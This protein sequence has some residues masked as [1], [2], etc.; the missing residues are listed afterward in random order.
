M[1]YMRSARLF[2]LILFIGIPFVSM[3]Q[4]LDTHPARGFMPNMDQ[5]S[6]PIDN[7]AVSNGKLHLQIPLASLPRG[8]AG[9]GFDLNLE[10]DSHIYD[11]PTVLLYFFDYVNY[12][13]WPVNY[14]WLESS[15]TG[16]GWTYN[17]NNYFIEAE[18][19]AGAIDD[20][21]CTENPLFNGNP[22]IIRYRLALPDGSMHILQLG[23]FE[24]YAPP[25]TGDGYNGIAMDGR[26]TPCAAGP[27]FGWP[28]QYTGWLSYYTNDG[29]YLKY[30]VYV[31]SNSWLNN[32]YASNWRLYFPNGK[33]VIAVNGV[34]REYDSNDNYVSIA[35]ACYDPPPGGDCS[36]PYT[37]IYDNSN[38]QIL[39]EYNI[40]DA[41][42]STDLWK[43]DQVTAPGPNGTITYSIDWQSF[44]V[45]G[46]GRYY[47][48]GF[49]PVDNSYLTI[50]LN[51]RL[52][53]VKYVQLPAPQYRANYPVSLGS[54][55]PDELSYEFGYWD[56]NDPDPDPGPG[57]GQ[58]DHMRTPSGSVYNY[59]YRIIEAGVP[60]CP[61]Q[62]P[63]VENIADGISVSQKNIIHDSISD[64]QWSFSYNCCAT[65]ITN[66]DG[67]QTT[68]WAQ[69]NSTGWD[70]GL[71]TLIVE[72]NGSKH[73]R[74]WAVNPPAA[75]QGSYFT[76]NNPY[77]YKEIATVG[78]SSGNSAKSA[79]TDFMYDKNGNLRSK[80]EYDWVNYGVE[81]GATIK[82]RT[83]FNY[84]VTGVSD[85]YVWPAPDEASAYWRPHNTAIWPQG[86]SRRLNGV[87]R[88]TVSDQY[89]ACAATEYSYD[90]AYSRGNVTAERRWDSKKALNLPGL[91][92]L[93]G[94]NSQVL[95]RAYDSYG[96]LVD[97]FEPEMRTHISYDS[98]NVVTGVTK[99]YQTSAP[100]SFQYSW[101]N[102]VALGSKIDLDNTT[103][104]ATVYTYDDVG[105]QLTMR[106]P[107]RKLTTTAYDD[108]NRKV[109]VTSDLRYYEDGKLQTITHYDQLGRVTLA[110]KSDGAVLNGDTDG[111]KVNTIYIQPSSSGRRV[112]AS[113]PYRNT[114]FSDPTVE[115]TCTQYDQ[116]DRVTMV[117]MFKGSSA[118]TD[119]GSSTNRTGVTT[120]VYN[121]ELTT[122]TDPA[123][124]VRAEWRDGLGRLAGVVEDPSGLNYSTTYDYDPLDNLYQVTQGSQQRYFSYSSLSRLNYAANPESGVIYYTYYD[125][126]DLLRR[127][128]ARGIWSEMTYDP[129]HRILTKTYSDG[130]PPVSYSYYLTGSP[131]IGQLAAVSSSVASSVYGY[132]DLGNITGSL[133]D[134]TGYSGS[135]L[136]GY[137]WYLNGSLS[138]IQ[139]PSGRLVSY[140]V[141][142]AGRTNRAYSPNTNYADLR[143]TTVPYPF[144]PDGRIAQMEL[145][146]GLYERRDYNTPG[147]ATAYKLETAHV[148][149]NNI[150]VD[151]SIL[152]ELDYNFSGSANNGNLVSQ[153]TKRQD[154]TW[155]QTQNH[156]YD[157]VNRLSRAYESGTFN[158]YYG[159]DQQGNRWINS[160]LSS[161]PYYNPDLREP[162]ENNA[163]FT[164]NRLLMSGLN[165]DNAGN[166]TAYSGLTLSYD[167]ENR[168]TAVS[169]GSGNGTFS[170]D[171]DGRRVRKMWTSGQTTKTTFFV[172]D[173]L[174]RM[175]AEYSTEAPTSTGTSYLFTDMLGSVRTITSSTQAVTECYD[176]LPFGRMLS[177]FDGGRGNLNCYPSDPDVGYSSI[178]SPKFTGKE[179][180]AETGL[181]YFGARY[182]SGALG[183][184]MSPDE[185]FADQH[186]DDPQ[187][188]NIYAYVRN[189]P[190]KNTDPSGRD[191]TEGIKECGEFL[192]GGAEAVANVVPAIFNIPTS[193]A[194]LVISPF[195]DF[196]F[197]PIATPIQASTRNIQE[198]QT[199]ANI[200]M[201]A[202]PLME[203]SA[204]K[205][206]GA[207]SETTK[208]E[209]V[210]AAISSPDDVPQPAS[211]GQTMVGPNGTAVRIPSGQVAE[212]AENG[213]G[214]VYRDPGT[215][216]NANTIRV[217]GPDAQGRYPNGYVRTYN[218]QGQPINPST[219]KPDFRKNTHTPF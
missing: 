164:N 175:A 196:R 46:D 211:Q 171:G 130:T 157:G 52:W 148:N 116:L 87:L 198:G 197:Q 115:W 136:F 167:A 39:V 24:S 94:S 99:G 31:D 1:R 182:Y 125:S 102:G 86:S 109:T 200:T 110:Q 30:E 92:Q 154:A 145:G 209:S 150:L 131:N 79:I 33:R 88:R 213:N 97:I 212:K 202:S 159:Y 117:A 169:G 127:T 152:E 95:S 135:L 137:N 81:T 208:T 78:D 18:V 71:T 100:R 85:A 189:N 156:E 114:D 123:S 20:W 23:G 56:N 7:I 48:A 181:D 132:D 96:N 134:I 214:I 206:V 93:D 201:M 143:L 11:K 29:S 111:I 17:A 174:G 45:G 53:V 32:S 58:V 80:T 176:Y 188:W 15:A 2:S 89:V 121:A 183:R 158:R 193:F 64:M 119:C 49:N 163:S 83:E 210:V 42:L 124:K 16:G 147:T 151:D 194:N 199:A 162:T 192:L 19:K 43:R 67:G 155:T 25:S 44:V 40:T 55:P 144:A 170:Y 112:I 6:S 165:Y 35:N 153:V 9:S 190:I 216:G 186:P 51:R 191:C 179:R 98:G 59:K 219:G 166:Q 27:S 180:D 21:N 34:I 205:I 5:L 149:G 122:I 69:R 66:P 68:H 146:N 13:L 26:S 126:G 76:P 138:S 128:D 70:N 65:T 129:L 113:T 187:S 84:Y 74:M 177:T 10:Y 12:Q 4:D 139:Y 120:T 41:N 3:A 37:S 90:D 75:L 54:V 38:R 47:S 203:A 161:G 172:Y 28:Q 207:I 61:T 103:I 108:A 73:K 8:R 22:R 133:H 195:T 50:P 14:S 57:Y 141:D 218:S 140:D 107:N 184:F 104:S 217:M 106:V 60:V 101:L 160:S 72:P 185:V 173:A 178:E 63:C 168:N 142:D 118:P 82:R 36:R 91:G 204:T 215:A 105:R 77:V 62:L